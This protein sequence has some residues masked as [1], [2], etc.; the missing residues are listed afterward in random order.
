MCENIFLFERLKTNLCN[1]INDERL[2]NIAMIN[3]EKKNCKTVRF[4]DRQYN[5]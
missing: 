5:Q 4:R 1:E 2:S 3:I